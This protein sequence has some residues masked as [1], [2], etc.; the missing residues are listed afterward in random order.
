MH[1]I[2]GTNEQQV[3]LSKCWNPVDLM[4]NDTPAMRK[5]CAITVIALAINFGFIDANAFQVLLMGQSCQLTIYDGE[6]NCVV[7]GFSY[8]TA[9]LN[10]ATRTTESKCKDSWNGHANDSWFHSVGRFVRHTHMLKRDTCLA[11]EQ[12]YS[13]QK[14]RA[15][16]QIDVVTAWNANSISMARSYTN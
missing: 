3:M 6:T 13:G 11:D 12:L 1:T 8:N 4:R 2:C 16:L 10:A 9:Q 14:L 15:K 5:C 7:Q